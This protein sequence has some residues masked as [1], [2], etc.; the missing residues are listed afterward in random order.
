MSQDLE[1]IGSKLDT[2]LA[3]RDRPA[4]PITDQLWDTADVAHYFKRNAQVVHES[5][6]SLPSFP[7]ATRL[8]SK[9]KA[10][11]LQSRRNHRVGNV[12]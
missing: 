5:M 8:P 9:G 6:T 3:L 12:A 2:I 10:H 11:P 7:K 4:V 1:Q